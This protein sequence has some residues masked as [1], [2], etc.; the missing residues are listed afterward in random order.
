MNLFSLKGKVAL[1]TGGAGVLGGSMVKILAESGCKVAVLEYAKDRLDA[2]V[3]ELTQAGHQALG[4]VGNVLD[5][6]SL[7]A[8]RD[9]VLQEWGT[10]DI[11]VNCA[12]GNQPGAT[13][14]PS[15]TFFDLS[16]DDLDKVMALNLKGTILP[17]MVFGEVM[18]KN[19]SGSIIN[20]SSM[21]AQQAL[22]RVFGYSASKAGI[23]NITRWLAVEMAQK[24]G[25]GIRVNAIA[26]GFFI[27]EQNRRLLLEEDGSWTPRAKTIISQT[28]M[29]RFGEAEELHG[30]LIWL[31]SD[32]ASFVTGTVVAV[33][34]GFG[35]FSGV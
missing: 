33:D 11:L 29:G 6:E 31:A 4:L 22:T 16:L 10:I 20:M 35:A 26:P 5:K 28:P 7:E 8:A 24:F 18:A 17:I 19:K 32:A 23:D 15:Q 34:G 2:F 25:E 13:I 1:V 21:S 27:G 3:Q 12:G 9:Q 30:V 14:Q